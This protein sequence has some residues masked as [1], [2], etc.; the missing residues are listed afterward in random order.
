MSAEDTRAR[1]LDAV[2]PVFAEHGYAGASTRVL[3][4]AAGVNIATLAYHFGDKEGLY[5]AVIDRIYEQLLAIDLDLA[6]LPPE[7]EGRVRQVMG[8]LWRIARAHRVQVAILLR[9]VLD[10]QHLPDHVVHERMPQVLARAG[11]ALAALDLG[12][13]AHP[14]ALLSLN[15]LLAR[16]AVTDAADLV[17]FGADDEVI[18][19]HLGDVAVRL[20]LGS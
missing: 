13:K 12:P 4:A 19:R 5:V 9:H 1:V 18:E 7:R 11:A 3:A 10:H 6:A 8:L 14:L 2:G 17:A 15:H 20:L 16:Y